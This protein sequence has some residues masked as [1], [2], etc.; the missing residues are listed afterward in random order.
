LIR[1]GRGPVH[2]FARFGGSE[3][4]RVDHDAGDVVL[5]VARLEEDHLVRLPR[6][7]PAVVLPSA[8][9]EEG[10]R[11]EDAHAATRRA[12]ESVS[13]AGVGSGASAR[14]KKPATIAPAMGA[15]Q[16]SHSCS[17]AQPPTK[18]AVPVERAG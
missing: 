1:R 2:E 10:G 8:G 5:A 17:I 12:L 6:D 16:K 3:P 14:Q 18:T 9:A 4:S 13:F 11:G 7:A 15:T